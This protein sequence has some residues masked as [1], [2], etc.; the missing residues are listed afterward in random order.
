MD[1]T[2]L[3]ERKG[4][5]ILKSYSDNQKSFAEKVLEIEQ[6]LNSVVASEIYQAYGV[7]IRFHL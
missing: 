7:A 4:E 1:K 3:M 5:V 2:K 6:N